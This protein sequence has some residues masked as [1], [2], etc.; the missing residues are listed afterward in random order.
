MKLDIVAVVYASFLLFAS[1]Q[2]AQAL[3]GNGDIACNPANYAQSVI[4]VARLLEHTNYQICSLTSQAR[5]L[6]NQGWPQCRHDDECPSFFLNVVTKNGNAIVSIGS[7]CVSD[8][9]HIWGVSD[10]RGNIR[11][12]LDGNAATASGSLCIPLHP[13]VDEVRITSTGGDC[14]FEGDEEFTTANQPGN[15]TVLRRHTAGAARTS[16][17]LSGCHA[18]IGNTTI[19]EITYG[20]VALDFADGFGFGDAYAMGFF[21][22]VYDGFGADRVRPFGANV[23]A[24]SEFS[25]YHYRIEILAHGQSGWQWGNTGRDER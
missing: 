6:I 24:I 16:A 13:Y 14:G 17:T 5:I 2:G 8:W 20:G 25:T 12:W 18:R 4:S 9:R 15:D 22:A 3:I 21:Y 1:A 23:Y 19:G 7:A 10:A 11:Q